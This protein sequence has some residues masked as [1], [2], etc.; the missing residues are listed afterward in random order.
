MF[1]AVAAHLNYPEAERKP[2]AKLLRLFR[3]QP[4][5]PDPL[6]LHPRYAGLRGRY[7]EALNEGDAEAIEESFLE[8]YCHLHGHEAPYTAAERQR[9][10]E[11]GG[12]WCHA[13]G[14]SPLLKAG[15]FIRPETVSADFGAGN[16]LQGLLL[17]HLYPHRQTIQIEISSRLI[18]SGRSLQEWLDIPAERVEW[19]EA[20]VMDVRPEGM[21]F[22]YL[23]RPVRPEGE[24]RRFYE[25]F[26]AA[27]SRSRERVVIF[28]VADCLKSFLPGTFTIFHDD[29]HLTCFEG[30]RNRSQPAV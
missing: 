10:R 24:G 1:D 19:R 2:L 11:T 17:Q 23:Y 27:L 29:G 28:S 5:P 3:D 14:I 15:P 21:D 25:D 18:A 12:Y 20:D 9:V 30:L 26:A 4:P 13:G 6:G 22:I 7:L 8:L 16:G